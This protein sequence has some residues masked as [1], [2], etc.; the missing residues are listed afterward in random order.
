MGQKNTNT[1]SEMLH[2]AMVKRGNMNYTQLS[3]LLGCSVS[4]VS[5]KFKQNNFTESD[6]HSIANA[7]GYNIEITLIS[8]ESGDVLKTL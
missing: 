4:N 5:R 7:L 6:M 8:K 1:F 2:Y 3:K